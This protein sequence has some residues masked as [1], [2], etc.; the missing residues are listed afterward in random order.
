MANPYINAKT[1]SLSDYITPDR[2]RTVTAECRHDYAGVSEVPVELELKKAFIKTLSFKVQWDGVI[3]GFCRGKKELTAKL[4]GFTKIAKVSIQD[5]N[6]KFLIHFE[7]SEKK[8]ESA[9]FVSSEE[10]RTLLENCR[11]APEQQSIR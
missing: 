11:R 5:W 7:D 2:F 10:V 1:V 6:D 9:F 4:E 8:T 3:Y